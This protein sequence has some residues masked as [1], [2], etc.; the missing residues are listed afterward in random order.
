VTIWF[1]SGFRRLGP[2]LRL[3][4]DRDHEVL[5]PSLRLPFF[6]RVAGFLRADVVHCVGGGG[7]WRFAL[8]LRFFRLLGKKIVVQ[9]I[10]TDV[11]ALAKAPGPVRRS[12]AGL[13]GIHVADLGQLADELKKAGVDAEVLPLAVDLPARPARPGPDRKLEKVLTYIPEGRENFY[14]APEHLEIWKKFPGVRFLVAGHKGGGRFFS[15]APSNVEFLG[16]R[17]GISRAIWDSVQAY[18]RLTVHDGLSLMIV[19]ALARGKQAVWSTAWPGCLFA[20]GAAGVER[21]LKRFLASGVPFNR[22]GRESALKT[23]DPAALR[24]RYYAMYERL[25]INDRR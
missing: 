14:L 16:T 7:S 22:K 20:A 6:T 12:I 1:V 4:A 8:L 24:K 17:D 9:W 3:V 25:T 10:G 15:E 13:A 21:V 11:M 2:L 5:H 19:E 23:F 18:V